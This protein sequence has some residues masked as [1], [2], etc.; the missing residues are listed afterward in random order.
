VYAFLQQKC[1]NKEKHQK[2]AFL[3]LFGAANGI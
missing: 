1:F 3:V 2:Q